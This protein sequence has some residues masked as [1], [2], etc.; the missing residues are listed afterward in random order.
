MATAF[1]LATSLF[2]DFDMVTLTRQGLTWMTDDILDETGEHT[3]WWMIQFNDTGAVSSVHR[4]LPD[5]DQES[6]QDAK[7]AA[8]AVWITEQGNKRA[9]GWK[10]DADGNLYCYVI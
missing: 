5:I 7:D 9:T 2:A 4:F 6:V 3:G 10:S 8:D 1:D